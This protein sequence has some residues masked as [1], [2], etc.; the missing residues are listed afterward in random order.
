MDDQVRISRL[1]SLGASFAVYLRANPSAL[2]SASKMQA[3]IADILGTDQ[4]LLLPIR[5]L[6]SQPAGIP[7]LKLAGT[8]TGAIQRDTALQSISTVFSSSIL[9][10]L[11]VFIDGFLDLPVRQRQSAK[12]SVSNLELSPPT[13]RVKSQS[14]AAQQTTSAEAK[15]WLPVSLG[16][17]TTGLLVFAFLISRPF[18]GPSSK[19]TQIETATSKED[20]SA[21]ALKRNGSYIELGDSNESGTLVSGP[22]QVNAELLSEKTAHGGETK[23]PVVAVSFNGQEVGRL[24][25]SQAPYSSSIVQIADLDPSNKY[26]EVILSSFTGGAHCCNQV[27]ALTSDASGTNWSEVDL[28]SYDGGPSPAKDPLNNGRYYITVADNRFL[29]QFTNY[30]C[31]RAPT[32]LLRLAGKTLKDVTLDQSFIPYHTQNLK[33]FEESFPA[34]GDSAY[35]SDCINGFLAGYV[36]TK[37][38]VGEL[39]SG[40]RRMLEVYFRNSDWGLKECSAG[41]DESG[42]CQGIETIYSSFPEALKA[43]LLRAGY[44]KVG[45]G[46]PLT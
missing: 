13:S 7:L 45:S 5:E 32:R 24:L 29:Y 19:P 28:G 46:L 25:G 14:K 11:E 6:I 12:Q 33:S 9:S 31:S 10:E 3:V 15:N 36:A 42:N 35:D 38:L 27:T 44:I 39:D 26:P 8:G 30:A 41:L 16:L 18:W 1:R 37:S 34:R 43:L 23:T 40:W 2:S 4:S 17:A 20:L 22:I 21:D